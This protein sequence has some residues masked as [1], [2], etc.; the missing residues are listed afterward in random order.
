MGG[1]YGKTGHMSHLY[2]NPDL[3]F[4]EMKEILQAAANADLDVEEKLDGQNLY[5]S[6]SIPEGKAKASRNLTH[7]RN[8]GVDAMGLANKFAGRGTLYDAFTN[9]FDAFE[10]A[11]ET[12]SPEAREKVFGPDTNFWYNAEV[13]D[14]DNP[15]IINYDSKTLKIHDKG[16]YRFDR[17]AKDGKGDKIF[18]DFTERLEILDSHLDRIQKA[19]EN[20]DFSLIRDAALQLKKMSD[21]VPLRTVITKI[22]SIIGREGLN[23]NDTVGDYLYKR[24]HSGLDTDLND[25]K[26]EE[27]TNYLL[28]L[29]S[30]VGLRAIKKGLSPEDTQDLNAIIASKSNI[31][32]QA[33]QPVE[34]VIHDFTVE[35]LKGMESRFILDNDKETER[36]QNNLANAVNALTA[37]GSEDP[38]AIEIMQRHLNKIKDFVNISTPIEGVVFDYNGHTY[39]FTGN[40]A[41]LNQI[42]G[43][44]DPTK[45]SR[46]PQ[47]PETN[48]ESLIFSKNI[49]KE[50]EE[51]IASE[52]SKAERFVL[53]LPK[54]TPTEAWGDPHSMERQQIQRI[55]DTVGGGATISEKLQ[56]LNDTIQNPR[57]GIRSPRR[58]IS[59]LI[60][61]E[62]LKAVIESFQDAPAGFVFEGFMSALLRGKQVASRTEKGNLPIQDLIAFSELGNGRD[63]PVSLKLLKGLAPGK[64]GKITNIEGSYTNLVDSLDEFGQMVYIVGRKDGE[65]IVLEKF[66]FTQDN[67]LRALVTG[68]KGEL[69]KEANLFQLPGKT[70]E[71]SIEFLESIKDW[72]TKYEYL[73]TTAGY[74]PRERARKLSKKEKEEKVTISDE[75]P[76][77]ENIEAETTEELPGNR[78]TIN[79]SVEE[80]RRLCSESLLLESSQTQWSISPAQLR[81]IATSVDYEKL[82]SL[83]YDSRHITG[84]AE[85]YMKYLSDNLLNVFE[86]TKELSEN[87]TQYFTF[88]RRSKAISSGEEAIQNSDTIGQEMTQQ[89]SQDQGLGETLVKEAA[90]TP[91]LTNSGDQSGKRIALFPGKFKPPHRGHYEFAKKVAKR[92]DVDELVIL[93]SPSSKPEVNPQQ[94]LSIWN[95]FLDSPDAPD[96]IQVE[97]ADYRSPITSVYEYVA[98]PVKARSGDTIML[99]KSSKDFGDTRFEGAQSYAERNNPGVSVELIEEDPVSRPDGTPY[100]GE[101]A[102]EAIAMNDAVLFNTFV[103]KVIDS[104]EIWN[105]FHP[106]ESY[107]EHVDFMI[108]EISAMGSGAVSGGGSGFGPPNTYNPYTPGKVKKPK[109]K[110]AKRQRRK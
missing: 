41:P 22:N 54:F 21:D 8:K 60:I 75:V 104:D 32:Q 47:N 98:D 14:P 34:N 42:L 55:F 73:Q 16:H 40:F 56:F 51:K 96:N 45:Y 38:A 4:Q 23:D 44:V 33:I 101:D 59:M 25:L 26:K 64:T 1:V 84:V 50:E 2:D 28:K 17:K 79:Y 94:S 92:K 61:L 68:F 15:N 90:Y 29:P 85:K 5:L 88:R 58:I 76:D 49:I 109:V 46:G 107:N 89:I 9:S 95:K 97:I 18:E 48:N 35:L 53:S 24:V 105:I 6:Y 57:G 31:L 19:L 108:D 71:E 10:K 81:N 82:G 78:K 7:L 99:I 43:M 91:G 62:S 83:P 11:V 3:T 74:D 103:P 72:P 77:G 63:V 87:I 65:H 39:K 12:M 110:R 67:F 37:T 70:N 66:T 106:N 100:N 102:R 30:N 36:L 27:I 93:I 69:V 13:M 80:N 20:H 86:A 52:P